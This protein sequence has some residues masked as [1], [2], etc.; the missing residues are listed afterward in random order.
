MAGR[1]QGKVAFITGA[2][3]GQG[4]AHAIRLAEEGADIIAT[5]ICAPVASIDYATSTVED[6]EETARQVRALDRRVVTAVADI[7]DQAAL[8]AAVAQG[9]DELGGLDIVIA[10]AGIAGWAGVEE[11][12]EDEWEEMI[13][14]NLT[15]AWKTIRA[16]LPALRA[17]GKG[18]IVITSSAA[19]LIGPAGLSHYVAAKHGLVGLMRGLN[20]ELAPSGIRINT[21][22]PT[23]V[24]TP[25]ILHDSLYHLF[26]PDLEN[27][28]EA[29]IIAPSTALNLM[30]I[31]WV[32]PVDIANAAL[33]LAS[34]EARYITG[35]TL[36]VDAGITVKVGY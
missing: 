25:M 14:I 24:N 18:S 28:T 17:A 7:R 12:T 3:R 5:D 21:I 29:D 30:P 4:R 19:G 34:D 2:A 23:Q 33:F 27:P 31:P 15:G 8:S 32:E 10:N 11:L 26:R 13:A 35:T 1:V 9:V 16:C 6:L 36:T 22:H 20:N